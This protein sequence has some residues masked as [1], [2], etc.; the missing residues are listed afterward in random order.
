MSPAD[1]VTE[2]ISEH[3][4]AWEP[5]S[6]TDIHRFLDALPAI[7]ET[8]AEALAAVADRLDAATPVDTA[9]CE[10]LRELAAASAGHAELARESVHLFRARHEPELERIENPRAGEEMFDVTAQD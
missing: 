7:H 8:L 9:V 3:I 6:A 5:S 2:A 10:H 4:G 1:A